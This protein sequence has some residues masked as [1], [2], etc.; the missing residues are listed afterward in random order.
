MKF[1]S[2][3]ESFFSSSG[4]S[5]KNLSSNKNSRRTSNPWISWTQSV[6]KKVA[7]YRGAALTND[8]IAHTRRAFDSFPFILIFFIFHSFDKIIHLK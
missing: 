6:T 4:I 7:A 8:G 5:L 3:Y 2:E 1:Y